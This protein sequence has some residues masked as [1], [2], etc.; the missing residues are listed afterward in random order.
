MQTRDFVA[1][2][3]RTTVNG[4]R[5]GSMRRC[6]RTRFEPDDW[7]LKPPIETL[8]QIAQER[9]MKVL[10]RESGEAPVP[11]RAQRGGTI[12]R[13]RAVPERGPAAG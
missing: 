1:T 5:F 9:A 8:P 12:P 3:L 13:T 2:P 10:G 6:A 7:G 4:W 11:V